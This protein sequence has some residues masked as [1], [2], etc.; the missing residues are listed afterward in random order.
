MLN[1]FFDMG[2]FTYPGTPKS[3]LTDRAGR[4]S[5]KLRLVS[6]G[7]VLKA[8]HGEPPTIADGFDLENRRSIGLVIAS[9][10]L[11]PRLMRFW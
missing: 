4:V 10:R 3:D 2:L 11:M 8:V 5:M 6:G 7:F 9:M 1:V